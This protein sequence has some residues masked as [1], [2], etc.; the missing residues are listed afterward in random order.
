MLFSYQRSRPGTSTAVN[1]MRLFKE[2]IDVRIRAVGDPAWPLN[3]DGHV[4]GKSSRHSRLLPNP[5]AYHPC[6]LKR[7][8]RSHDRPRERTLPDGNGR[9]G[10]H[11]WINGAGVVLPPSGGPWDQSRA[12][13][14]LVEKSAQEP[15]GRR[16]EARQV[17]EQL[18][19]L[20]E[21]CPAS[22]VLPESTLGT[23]RKSPR[24]ERPGSFR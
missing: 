19:E 15:V 11:G 1:R 24:Q 17:L 4:H 9:S 16:G 14:T 7:S 23:L 13:R 22:I 18:L 10:R 12:P 20:V 2:Q 5:A 6:F 8:H 3:A 21:P